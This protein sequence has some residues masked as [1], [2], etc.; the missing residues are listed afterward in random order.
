MSAIG[1]ARP[2][3]SSRKTNSRAVKL[4]TR[5]PLLAFTVVLTMIAL[6]YMANPV[7]AGAEA[8][9]AF[10][11]PGGITV[12]L[13]GLAGFPLAFAAFFAECLFSERRI[14]FGLRIELMLLGIVMGIRLLGMLLTHSAETARLFIPETAMALLCIFAIRLEIRRI[15]RERVQSVA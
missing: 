3:A 1:G 14:L 7:H 4:F 12:A 10:T 8:G 6:R 11:S 9:I 15:K 5:I 2:Q 13:V